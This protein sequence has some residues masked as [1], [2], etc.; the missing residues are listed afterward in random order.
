[1]SRDRTCVLIER[2]LARGRRA[3]ADGNEGMA[4]VCARRAAGI[5][6]GHCLDESRRSGWAA[7]AV[8]R[9]RSVEGDGTF[10]ESVRQ[11]ARRLTARVREDFTSPFQENPLDDAHIIV[12]HCMQE[13]AHR[14]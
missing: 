9:L 4:R 7:D 11:A 1:M 3:L 13:E 5:A 8:H 12:T 6:I 14:P 10:P 2:E